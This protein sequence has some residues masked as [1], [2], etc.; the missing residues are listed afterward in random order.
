MTTQQVA[1]VDV[2][3]TGEMTHVHIGHVTAEL[4]PTEVE[5]LISRLQSTLN[6]IDEE[7]PVRET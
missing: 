5:D 7:H 2:T 1:D 6:Q 4:W 3:H